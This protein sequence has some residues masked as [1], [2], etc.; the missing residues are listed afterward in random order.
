MLVLWVL[1]I[2]LLKKKWLLRVPTQISI[3][4]VPMRMVPD[5]LPQMEGVAHKGHVIAS[6]VVHQP[7]CM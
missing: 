6:A 5:L 1:I 4:V 3:P 2:T 7:A